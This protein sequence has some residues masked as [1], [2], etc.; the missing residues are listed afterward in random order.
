MLY[1]SYKI[2]LI[3]KYFVKLK[4]LNFSKKVSLILFLKLMFLIKYIFLILS[5]LTKLS[6]KA[7]KINLRNRN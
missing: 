2:I 5:S 4:S 6:I 7:L 3:I 1:Y